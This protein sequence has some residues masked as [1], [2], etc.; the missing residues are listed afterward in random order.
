MCPDHTGHGKAAPGMD[1]D[2]SSFLG[3][4]MGPKGVPVTGSLNRP[5]T[6]QLGV[7]FQWPIHLN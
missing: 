5:H 6:G 2:S 1:Q 4:P 7:H 3:R